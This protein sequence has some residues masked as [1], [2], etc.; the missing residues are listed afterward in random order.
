MSFLFILLVMAGLIFAVVRPFLNIL[1]MGFILAVL[2]HPIESWFEKRFKSHS[3]AALATI[4]VVLVI[5][6]VPVA[7]LGQVVFNEALG[8]YN[9]FKTGHFVVDRGEIISRLPIQAQDFIA[10]TTQDLNSLVSRLTANAFQTFS[11]LVSNLATFI[12][13]FFLTLFAAYYFLKD[14]RHFKTV[15]ID[16][17]PIDNH[18]ERILFKKIARAV[19]GVVKGQFITA[20]IQGVVATVGYLIFG[21]PNA[22]LWGVFTLLAALVPTVGTALVM[23][24]AVLYL[25]ITGSVG[26]AIGLAVWGAIAVGLIDNVLGPRILGHST[27]VH[28]LLMLIAVLGGVSVFGFLGFLLGPILMAIFVAMVDMYR[29]EF[30]EYLDK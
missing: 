15:L 14:G 27:K 11:S 2:F 8:L 22:F 30:Q 12:L 24:P 26:A 17:S 9:N 29:K 10:T 21:L 3:L 19:N 7:L 1:V 18:Q 5:L 13:S 23:I 20:L 25:L 28:P 16:I 6:V 4:L